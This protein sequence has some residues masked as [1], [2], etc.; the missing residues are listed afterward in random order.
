MKSRST[1]LAVNTIA[2]STGATVLGDASLVIT[3]LS[4][5]SK[6]L[7][8]TLTFLRLTSRSASVRKLSSLPVMGVLIDQAMVPDESVQKNLQC[9]L[10]V[11]EEPQRAFLSC[12]PLFY[13][14]ESV[15]RSIHPTAVIDPSASI[16]AGVAIGPYCVIGSGVSIKD[17]ATLHDRVTLYRDVTIG[18]GTELHSGVVIREGCSIG[19]YCCL[20]NQTVVGGDGFGYMSDPKRGIVKVPQVGSV[21]IGDY[22]EIGVGS[23]IDRGAVG[24]TLIGGHTKIDNHVQIGHNVTVGSYS[25]ICAQVGIGGSTSLGDR[26]VVGGATGIADHLTIAS[27][28]RLGGRSGATGDIDTPGDYMGHPAIPAFQYRRMQAI[29]KRLTKRSRTSE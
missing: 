2:Q 29:L 13:E 19:D 1:S 4:P 9:T 5:V 25:I 26:V 16:G 24:D 28:V 22:V 23:S 18:Q 7:A 11:V 17:N 8:N 12:I 20:H 10:L 21:I 3:G 14:E 27:G 6:P 15:P